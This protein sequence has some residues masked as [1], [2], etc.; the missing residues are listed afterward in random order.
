VSTPDLSPIVRSALI[1]CTPSVAFEFYTARMAEWWPLETHSIGHE[2]ATGVTIDPGVGGRIVETNANGEA[3]W[4]TVVAWDPPARV[5]H[6]WHP[7]RGVDQATEV[8]VT[9]ESEGDETR[10]TIEHRGWHKLGADAA[11]RRL[12]YAGADAWP[13]ILELMANAIDKGAMT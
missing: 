4:G 11:E 5:V 9:F 12:G 10:V 2:S 13:L 1:R 8:E 7:G 6:S 3:L